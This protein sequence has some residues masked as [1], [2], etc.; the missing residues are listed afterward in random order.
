MQELSVRKI[1]MRVAL[2]SRGLVIYLAFLFLAEL[3]YFASTE[4]LL[5]LVPDLEE[6]LDCLDGISACAAV[7]FGCVVLWA[8]AVSK[9]YGG[10]LL[11]D[12]SVLRAVTERKRPVPATTLLAFMAMIYLMQL[13]F[14]VLLELLEMLLN[15]GGMTILNSPAMNMDYSLDPALFIYAVVIGPIAEEFVFRGFALKSLKPCGKMFAIVISALTF[16]LMHGD[17]Q[18]LAFTFAVGLLLAY[19]ALEY[20]IYVSLFLHIFNNGVLSELG[21]L[22]AE[23]LSDNV[24]TAV[25]GCVTLVSIFITVVFLVKKRQGIREY[26]KAD[27]TEPGAL[28]G[29]FNPWFILFTVFGIMETLFTISPV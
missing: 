7:A 28:S 26:L 9:N 25:Y 3:V 10:R 11:G 6:A 4:V 1:K 29:L 5:M 12:E 24:Y 21:I 20:S 16:S 17:I 2:V 14:G 8:F 19:A 27:R 23:Y 22:A 13:F 18:Q 15:R